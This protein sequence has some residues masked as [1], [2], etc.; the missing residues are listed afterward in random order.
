MF[1]INNLKVIVQTV[2]EEEETMKRFDNYAMQLNQITK[3]SQIQITQVIPNIN[4]KHDN[5]V[6]F[7]K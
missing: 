5:R 6:Y 2:Q 1:Y 7:I 4:F 3:S